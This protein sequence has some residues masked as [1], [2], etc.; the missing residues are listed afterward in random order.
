MMNMHDKKNH[1]NETRNSI[2]GLRAMSKSLPRGLKTILKKGGHN[3]SSVINNWS[4]LVGKKISK[5]C[6]PK[7]IKTNKELKDGILFLNVAHGDQLLVEY[8]KK[9]IIDK[10]NAFFGYQFVREIR[11]SLIKEKSEF[12]IKYASDKPKDK[13][14]YKKIETVENSELKK[15]L[16]NLINVFS[17]KK[18]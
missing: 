8:S 12:N 6:Y 10:I 14:Y 2:Q 11:I 3:Y 1:N 15:K 9:D 18:V 17:S 16:V 7:L 4:T 13:K 5:I